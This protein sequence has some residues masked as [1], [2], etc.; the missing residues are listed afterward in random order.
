MKRRQIGESRTER[1]EKRLK[2][3]SELYDLAFK[4]EGSNSTVAKLNTKLNLTNNEEDLL[5][6]CEK[7][8]EK[9]TS[10]KK[11]NTN[12]KTQAMYLKVASNLKAVFDQIRNLIKDEFRSIRNRNDKL[13]QMAIEKL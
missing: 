1:I 4:T 8:K 13:P 12:E 3:S 6:C 2:F 5:L 7:I 10:L 9:I 11:I